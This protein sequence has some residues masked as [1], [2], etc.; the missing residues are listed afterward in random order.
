ML[1]EDREAARRRAATATRRAGARRPG[2]ALDP[3]HFAERFGLFL[4]ILLGEVV[5]E[6]GRPRSTATSRAG[7][8]GGARRAMVLAGALWWLY[9]DSAA[10]L[11]LKVLE[12]SGG[13]PTMARAIFAVGHM[14]PAFALLITAAGVG[15]LLEEDPPAIAYWLACVGIGIYLAGTR[16][17]LRVGRVPGVAAGA[18]ARGDVLA[19]R[20]EPALAPHEYLWLLA[21]WV[22]LCAALSTRALHGDAEGDLDR[23]LGAQP[24][25]GI[26]CT[27]QPFPSGSLK[28]ANP[29]RELLDLAGL[30]A[31]VEQVG[32]RGL[33]V[34]DDELEALNGARLVSRIPVPIA[35]EQPEPGGVGCTKRISSLTRVV[36]VV[37]EADLLDVEG[38]RAVHVRRRGRRPGSSSSPCVLPFGG[39]L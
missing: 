30:D 33:G 12:L 2:E 22:A 1:A 29:P 5:V 32:T 18:R 31:A 15:L 14:L 11:N 20:L 8:L 37:V 23:Y 28:N 19:R 7:R 16:A 39:R 26:A 38:L 36:V 24:R 25:A 10:E 4:I 34:G 21:V 3:H 27:A 17:F 6:A 13:S 9:F 35:I